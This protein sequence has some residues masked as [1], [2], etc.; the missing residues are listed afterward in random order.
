MKDPEN[1]HKSQEWIVSSSQP[2]V[3]W[4]FP[5]VLSLIPQERSPGMHIIMMVLQ[6]TDTRSITDAKG[7]AVQ[8]SPTPQPAEH[9]NS[10]SSTTQKPQMHGKWKERVPKQILIMCIHTCRSESLYPRSLHLQFYSVLA[11]C[12]KQ[13]FAHDAKALPCSF[14]KRSERKHEFVQHGWLGH[15]CHTKTAQVPPAAAAKEKPGTSNYIYSLVTQNVSILIRV[16]RK[17]E[18]T[19]H[20]TAFYS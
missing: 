8:P 2:A 17:F 1:K 10:L 20:H 7:S 9:S 12:C 13:T 3:P 6:L 19:I 15:V 5:L 16:E 14:T 18:N 11:V 4:G